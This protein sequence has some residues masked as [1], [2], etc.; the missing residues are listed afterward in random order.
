MAGR[1]FRK[2]F[3]NTSDRK[4]YT[5]DVFEYLKTIAVL[6]ATDKVFT[7][8]EIYQ[9]LAGIMQEFKKGQMIQRMKEFELNTPSPVVV[10]Q[11]QQKA[12]I[13]E[14]DDEEDLA[15]IIRKMN[16]D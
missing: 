11:N 13:T 3:N 14:I 15:I 7:E 4:H 12:T 5:E 16:I 9:W 2:N 8:Q 10:Q 1:K 6:L